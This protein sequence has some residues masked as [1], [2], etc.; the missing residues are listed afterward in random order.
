MGERGP[1][2]TPI[3][4]REV[5]GIASHHNKNDQAPRPLAILPDCPDWLDPQAKQEWLH[6]TEKMGKVVGWLTEVNQTTLAGHCQ[7]YSTWQQAEEILMKEGRTYEVVTGMSEGGPE[8]IKRIHP[9]VR[10]SREAWIAMMK[11]DME[12]GI[13]P[14]RGSSVRVASSVDE[15]DESGLDKVGR[16]QGA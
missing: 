9:A 15:N 14:A 8:I 2:P 16:S 3:A 5:L 7:W 11:C 13:T 1:A 12:L 6:I 4:L 10:V